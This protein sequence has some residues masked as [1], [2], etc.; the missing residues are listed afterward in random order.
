MSVA[1]DGLTCDAD[2]IKSN[3]IS[4][5]EGRQSFVGNLDTH[6]N[7]K[8]FR[9][10]FVGGSCVMW[11]GDHVV[12]VG[13]LPL[14]RVKKDLWRVK[15]S[16][17]DLVMHDLFSEETA[18]RIHGLLD[19]GEDAGAVAAFSLAI[20]FVR[21]RLHSVNSR[22]MDYRQRVTM[23][24]CS[25][26]GLTSLGSKQSTML[27]NKRNLATESIAYVHLFMRADVVNPHHCNSEPNE[28]TN[29]H[30]RMIKRECT[31]QD[32][33]ETQ[34]KR[35]RFVDAVF[36]SDLEV[37]REPT[38]RTSGG[39]QA[40]WPG[41]VT[42]AK[43]SATRQ[44]SQGGPVNVMED[45]GI[46][47]VDQIF[48][49]L[50]P[51]INDCAENMRGLLK[52]MGVGSEELSP[53]CRMFSTP[54]DLLEV[55]RVYVG[56]RKP[57]SV[58]VIEVDNEEA[59]HGEEEAGDNEGTAGEEQDVGTSAPFAASV[60][61]EALKDAIN[62]A[63]EEES[64]N[65]EYRGHDSGEATESAIDESVLSNAGHAGGGVY[66]L[67][68]LFL[69]DDMVGIA[70]AAREGIAQLQG[71]TSGSTSMSGKMKSLRERWMRPSKKDVTEGNEEMSDGTKLIK[72]NT[73]VL[74]KLSEGRGK[75]KVTGV[76]NFRVLGLYTKTYGKWYPCDVGCQEWRRGMEKGKFRVLARMVKFDHAV[77]RYRDV[78]VGDCLNWS[79]RNMF[80]LCD[81][82]SITEVLQQLEA[83]VFC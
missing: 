26:I 31:I 61:F 62:A 65:E 46:P 38:S 79:K 68:D 76:E 56:A 77:G 47:V 37:S 81:A 54:E 9:Y 19:A 1:V 3:L 72:R 8:G 83:C 45:G 78:R 80:L 59:G 42:R 36:E 5:L 43:Q 32:F 71:R 28:H 40:T 6:H 48:G 4:F 14:A 22:D 34:E 57:K 20:Y 75:K 33:V 13:F 50:R 74:V 11:L 35:R 52:R 70:T 24:W 16:F 23:M 17:L 69:A 10:Q 12:D 64:A 82:A 7:A 27:A 66:G 58:E 60:R 39:Y 2:W 51:I 49:C 63:L 53:F 67:R 44:N 55:Y 30:M 29:G 41:F 18:T 73:E 25:L 15:D 21:M